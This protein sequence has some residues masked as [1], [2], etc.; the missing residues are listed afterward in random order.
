MCLMMKRN[1]NILIFLG[2]GIVL[3]VSIFFSFN[4][5][6]AYKELPK[7]K[8]KDDINKSGL[9]IMVE[10]DYQTGEYQQSNS[11]TFPTDGYTLNRIKSGCVDK[12]G[13]NIDALTYN[14]NDKTISIKTKQSVYCYLYYDNLFKG[15]GTEEEPYQINYI[16]DL[17]R[18][19]YSVNKDKNNYQS[20]N[21]ILTRDLDFNENDSYMKYNDTGF[22][23]INGV[24]NIEGIKEE[25]TNKEGTGF[26]PIGKAIRFQGNFNG[27]NKRLDNIYEENINDT[28]NY[29]GLFKNIENSTIKNLTLS[30]NINT[31][32]NTVVGGL[33][34]N[35]Y[36][37]TTIDNCIIEVNANSDMGANSVGGLVGDSYG[38]LTIT[39]S[40][41]KGQLSGGNNTGGLVGWLYD[42]ST[43]TIENS[44]NEG[45]INNEVG[46]HAGGLLGRDAG[47]TSKT[48]I[49]NSYNVGEVTNAKQNEGGLVGYIYGTLKIENSYN[50]GK[51]SNTLGKNIGGLIGSSNNTSNITINNSY[52]SNSVALKSDTNIERNIGGLIGNTSGKLNINN[53][54]NNGNIENGIKVGGLIGTIALS[55]NEKINI[56]NSYNL[57]E[58][59]GNKYGG[60]TVG[61]LIG[62]TN[63]NDG[64]LII[65]DCYNL[66][67][68]FAGFVPSSSIIG[69]LMGDSRFKTIILNS[70]NAGNIIVDGKNADLAYNYLGSLI[71]VMRNDTIILNSY[72]KGDISIINNNVHGDKLLSGLGYFLADNKNLIINNFYNNLNEGR[73]ITYTYGDN[74]TYIISNAY[75]RNG[76]TAGVSNAT[77]LEEN[78]MLNKENIGDKTFVETLNNNIRNIDLSSIDEVL[79]DYKLNRW[80][81]GSEGY[82]VLD[83]EFIEDLSGNNRNGISYAVKHDAEGV[84][85][86]TDS[87]HIGYV[88]CGLS[89][90]DFGSDLTL[91]A[92][93]KF[94]A[95]GIG[96][97]FGSWDGSG[98]GITIS[99]N[100]NI[101]SDW[102]SVE[103]KTYKQVNS[104][105]KIETGKWYTIAVTVDGNLDS[106]N[107][108]LYIN[109]N[110]E[111]TVDLK[112]NIKPSNMPFTLGGNP[113]LYSMLPTFDTLSYTTFSEALIFD[114][115]LTEE[116]DHISTNYKD[117]INVT[118]QDE[119]L[120]WYKF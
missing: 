101:A 44:H 3:I 15:S 68:L 18:L 80:K 107:I 45:R 51:I 13:K 92:R 62:Y 47:A 76:L 94:N 58:I 24:N 43:L 99:R 30:G 103:E 40:I 110:K 56:N 5:N 27:N 64:L 53:S 49:K 46:A 23:D 83:G 108:K 52:N 10:S 32:V 21:F 25:L 114:R 2:I 33:I 100:N 14:E 6:N 118:N 79:K 59:S 119:L 55:T 26:E 87:S 84:T 106:E 60:T 66:G 85:T 115:A 34:G 4:K 78:Q 37:N 90:Y 9:A 38:K 81:Q 8:L 96:Y 98:G 104:S 39:N 117:D 19:S 113:N 109:G 74:N 86:S 77:A 20:K 1:K 112:V 48:I 31:K 72:N 116:K 93:V 63:K 22:G 29:L 12:N 17:V 73:G 89:N 71:S 28:N 11:T 69:G 88:N 42:N 50:T 61:G 7:V 111:G 35:S 57:G 120:L 70:Y 97:F 105:L 16:E 82:P 91:I 65:N 102:Y 95:N 67:N 54:Y 41:N 75:Y 36:G